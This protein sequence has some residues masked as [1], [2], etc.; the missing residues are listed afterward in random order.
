MAHASS[1]RFA[2]KRRCT[3][4]SSS[5]DVEHRSR[6]HASPAVAND[7][8]DNHPPRFLSSPTLQLCCLLHSPR[9]DDDEETVHAHQARGTGTTLPVYTPPLY[10]TSIVASVATSI[11]PA[12]CRQTGS[13]LSRLGCPVPCPLTSVI[14][15]QVQICHRNREC[16]L[17]KT[18]H[19][20]FRS[21]TPLSPQTELASL[22]RSL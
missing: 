14:S 4:R 3:A 9:A 20:R 8:T 18:D 7:T 21:L 11:Y 2:E 17:P 12:G 10:V 19:P 6:L 1:Q 22:L 15:A 16:P 13:L 5:S